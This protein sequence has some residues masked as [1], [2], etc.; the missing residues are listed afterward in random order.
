[1]G[2]IAENT[3]WRK[4]KDPNFINGEDIH[5]ELAGLK[6]ET[7]VYI[8]SINE[9][10]EIYDQNKGKGV[11][12]AGV[13]LKDVNGNPLP[14]PMV[15]NTSN[16]KRLRKIF[17]TPFADRWIGKDKLV[18]LCASPHPTCEWVVSFKEYNPK[19]PSNGQDA[20]RKLGL[21]ENENELTG[22]W[23]SLTAEDKN[24]KNVI[25]KKDEMKERLGI[26]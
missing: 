24:L 13:Y 11:K 12:V 7:V 16:S 4:F 22:L 9:G 2:N 19:P 14:K 10:T 23:K 3:H 21:C 25:D 1:M 6:T 26:A 15:L 18:I 17:G 20:I 5:Y 8:D